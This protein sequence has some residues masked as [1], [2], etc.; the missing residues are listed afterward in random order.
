MDGPRAFVICVDE[1]DLSKRGFDIILTLIRPRDSLRC[2]H[3]YDS[4]ID[5]FGNTKINDVS[6]RI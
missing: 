1:S 2:V 6:I 4:S 3:V 5:T